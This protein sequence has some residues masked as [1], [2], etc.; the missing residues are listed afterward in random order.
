MTRIWLSSLLVA[1]V[2]C[3]GS[4]RTS[5]RGSAST[6]VRFEGDDAPSY[7]S[8]V[9][10]EGARG[11]HAGTIRDAVFL[12]GKSHGLR[13]EGDPRL[14][15]IA[16]LL[17][18]HLREGGKL[19]P[20]EVILFLARHMGVTFPEIHSLLVGT[21]NVATIGASVSDGVAS[22]LSRVPYDRYGAYTFERDGLTISV[23]L[24]A[25]SHVELDPLP[26]ELEGAAELHVRGRLRGTL[27]RPELV[28]IH[29]DGRSERTS[30]GRGASIDHRVQLTAPG[31]A[32]LQILAQGEKGTVPVATLPI[33]VGVRHARTLDLD[34]RDVAPGAAEPEALAQGLFQLLS[35]ARAEAGS[36]PLT[37]DQGLTD[38]ALAHSRDM[39]ESSFM[40]HTS[41]THGTPSERAARAGLRSGLILENVGRG[42]SARDIHQ[43][44][45]A[46]PAHHRN[47]LNPDVTHVGI[48]VE[49]DGKGDFL[50]TQIFLKMTAAIDVEEARGKLLAA[51][52]EGRKARGAKPVAS[53]SNLEAAAAEG[54]MEYFADPSLDQHGAV[55]KANAAVRKFS[56]VF[57][58]VGSVMTVVDEVEQAYR[59]EPTFDPG[60]RY[61]GIGVAQGDRDDLPPNSIAIIV[62]LGWPR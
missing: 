35:A 62:L 19:P 3:G 12:A 23:V 56:I 13:L 2:A 25:S 51:I 58:R 27:S 45:V 29:P 48:G 38:L 47:L 60:I 39:R 59:L 40:G 4:Q 30:L 34:A 24:L 14:A 43:G 42:P 26:R 49:P 52:N 33:A 44:L 22:Y 55:A 9:D 21:P 31:V 1:L 8:I 15:A 32:R 18:P 5:L 20:A 46:S 61:V 10:G 50:V 17:E 41:P 53:D 36:P 7:E 6:Q 37:L 11:L 57:A 54:V 16:E 28:V